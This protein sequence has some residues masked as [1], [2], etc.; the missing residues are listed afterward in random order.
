MP[1]GGGRVGAPRVHAC[2]PLTRDATE[3]SAR[4]GR[5]SR[6][7]LLSASSRGLHPQGSGMVV[8]NEDYKASAIA[9][10]HAVCGDTYCVASKFSL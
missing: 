5:V 7:G 9:V 1:A 2:Q 3:S 8:R 6:L 4:I 10:R